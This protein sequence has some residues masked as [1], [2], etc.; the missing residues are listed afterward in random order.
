M[1]KTTL[2]R[3]KKNASLAVGALLVLAPLAARAQDEAAPPA[4]PFEPAAAAPTLES[5]RSRLQQ[6]QARHEQKMKDLRAELAKRD[7]E[8]AVTLER[9]AAERERLL[10]IYG[11]AD[12]GLRRNT[13]PEDALMASQFE[14]PLTFFLGRLNLYYDSHPAP[15][16]RFLAETR[17]SLYPNGV[18]SGTSDTGQIT[19]TSTTVG[20]ISSPNPSASVR[21]GSIILERAALDWTRYPFFS[22]RAGLFLTPFGIYN[23]D[24]GTPTLITTSLPIYISQ[25]FIPERQ[26]GIQIFGSQP[27]E[28]WE[29]GYAATVSNGRTDGILDVDDSKGFGGRLFARRQGELQLLLGASALYQPD[30]KNRE[31]FGMD[32]SGNLTYTTTR[33][34][35]AKLLT[36]GGDLSLDYSGL[37]VPPRR[38]GA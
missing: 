8:R 30:R 36:L 22:V 29:L 32:A 6:M 38:G 37:R 2:G 12:M 9:E 10:R 1:T 4:T 34:V 18:V 35:E 21:W 13:T 25:G 33:V 15:D 20:D 5:L 14:S 7:A 19:R 26:L 11:F 27:V 17:L 28:R 23:V 3:G 16:F 31:Q 24:H